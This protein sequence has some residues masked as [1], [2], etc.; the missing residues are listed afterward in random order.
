MLLGDPSKAREKF[1][2]KPKVTFKVS[3]CWIKNAFSHK[4][5][6]LCHQITVLRFAKNNITLLLFLLL[7]ECHMN[8][9]LKIFMV[10]PCINDI[11]PFLIQLMHFYSLLKQD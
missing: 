10:T 8:R 4:I 9:L 7:L 6:E 11:N 5:I 3:K 2:W 1:G